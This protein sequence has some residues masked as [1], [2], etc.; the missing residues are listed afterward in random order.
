M[1]HFRFRQRS[2]T[3]REKLSVN[4]SLFYLD[5]NHCRFAF[6]W[7]EF[8]PSSDTG[9]NKETFIWTLWCC[10]IRHFCLKHAKAT[11]RSRKVLYLS[12]PEEFFVVKVEF[13]LTVGPYRD[14]VLFDNPVNLTLK[15]FSA[16]SL[17]LTQP[18][19]EVTKL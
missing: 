2:S 15:T 19:Y 1:E 14:Y 10:A 13:L 5:R 9:M 17:K 3:S 16:I 18:P 7:E 4:V 11:S 8:F 6:L 12:T